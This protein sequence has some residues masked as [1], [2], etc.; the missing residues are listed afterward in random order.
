MKSID[1]DSVVVLSIT[2]LSYNRCDDLEETLDRLSKLS[3]LRAVRHEV[4]VVDNASTDGSA[5][6]VR[7]RFPAVR[8][9]PRDE[10]CGAPAMNDAIDL[11]RGDYIL[12]LDDDSHP[13]SGVAWALRFLD[14]NPRVGALACQI[15]GGDFRM[16]RKRH[17]DLVHGYI[18]CGAI[19]RRDVLR[20]VGG[21]PDWMFLYTNEWEHGLRIMAGGYELRYFE[22]CRVVHRAVPKNRSFRRLRLLT[23]RNE[24]L[25]IHRYFREHR[26]A[27]RLR[28]RI[29]FW[30]C[31][32]VYRE[33]LGVFRNV[34]DG[35]KQA[36]REMSGFPEI[37]I[38]ASVQDF[39]IQEHWSTRP[40]REAF[41]AAWRIVRGR[42]PVVPGSG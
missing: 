38:P 5:E 30:N 37:E 10:N 17:L 39:F 3:E 28:R 4:I 16:K 13:E 32:Y 33:G 14:A 34:Y 25:L 6:M 36:R 31:C 26:H 7:L 35:W 9:V 18:A 11:A 27:A 12:L 8:L 15:S 20:E 22:E 40:L 23:V 21:Y 2:I 1:S 41:G 19:L 24:L 29:L 42:D